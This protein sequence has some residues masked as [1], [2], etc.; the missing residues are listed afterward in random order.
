MV[1][2][3]VNFLSLLS[4]CDDMRTVATLCDLGQTVFAVRGSTDLEIGVRCAVT[5]AMRYA[6]AGKQLISIAFAPQLVQLRCEMMQ[7][8]NFLQQ[9]GSFVR[10]LST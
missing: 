7:K 10:V 9:K 4:V 6:S 1:S 3:C 8:G 5:G 2:L